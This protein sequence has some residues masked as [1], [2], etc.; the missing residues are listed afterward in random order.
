MELNTFMICVT[1]GG[2]FGIFIHTHLPNARGMM[3]RQVHM[4]RTFK[5]SADAEAYLK[6]VEKYPF[7][8]VVED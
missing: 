4:L 6:E 3:V 5:V 8:A 1:P 2:D 7:A